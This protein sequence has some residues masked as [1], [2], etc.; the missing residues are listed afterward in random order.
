MAVHY[1]YLY[2]VAFIVPERAGPGAATCL[3]IARLDYPMVF[4]GRDIEMQGNRDS[5]ERFTVGFQMHNQRR[6]IL[7]GMGVT[8][9]KD[10]NILLKDLDA[11]Q[12]WR[13][14]Q[15]ID[16]KKQAPSGFNDDCVMADLLALF[17]NF[18]DD[19][20]PPIRREL[21][22]KID[23]DDIVGERDAVETATESF[24]K[25]VLKLKKASQKRAAHEERIKWRLNRYSGF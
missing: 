9:L 25:R 24:W 15:N 17:G 1:G 19:A 8:A 11:I 16:G 12:E 5:P 6:N 13:V 18:G 7:I 3:K 20:A 23:P 10:G 2:N 21:F 14:F 4:H 22:N